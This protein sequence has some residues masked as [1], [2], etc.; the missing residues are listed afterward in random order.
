MN[1]LL[2]R[3]QGRA[4]ESGRLGQRPLFGILYVTGVIVDQQSFATLSP[5][6]VVLT[7]SCNL[8]KETMYIVLLQERLRL[9]IVTPLIL[10]LRPLCL[11]YILDI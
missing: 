4:L 10:D 3:E 1:E 11:S 5:A 6:S 9:S 2:D 7:K 8:K